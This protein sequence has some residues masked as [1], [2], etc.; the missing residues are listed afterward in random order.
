MGTCFYFDS[1]NTYAYN[2]TA[3]NCGTGFSRNTGTL[4]AKN[5]IAQ[6]TAYKGFNGTFNASSTNN[7]SSDATAPGSN[8]QNSKTITFANAA[9]NDFHLSLTD[10]AALGKGVNLSADSNFAFKTDID[11]DTRGAIWSIG[12][13]NGGQATVNSEQ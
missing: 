7:I 4:I 11:G 3:Y 5:N 2:N 6:N 1:S 13:D 9:A 10:T 8:A 12:A